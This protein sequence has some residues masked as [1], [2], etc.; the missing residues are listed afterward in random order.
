MVTLLTEPGGYPVAKMMLEIPDALKCMAPALGELLKEVTRQVERVAGLSPAAAYEEFETALRERLGAVERAAHEAALAALDID[1]SRLRID[2]VEYVRVGRH[3]TTFMS[4]A[5]PVPVMRSLY[6]RVG[7]RNGPTVDLVALR[8]AAV[9]GVWLPGAARA[10]AYLL[11]QGTSR[12]AES[13]A[14]ELGR[15]PYSRSSFERVGHAVG[16]IYASKREHVERDLIEAFEV[17]DEARSIS[18]SLDR[19]A[20]PMEEPRPRSVGRPRKGDAKRPVS[21]VFR[22]AYCGT[23]TIHDKN[24]EGL[25]TIRYGTMPGCD[26]QALCAALVD[27]AMALR[28]QRPRLRL[29][30]LCDG[31]PE[32]WNLLNDE[33]DDDI[34]RVTLLDFYH[35]IEKLSPAAKVL[36]GDDADKALKRWKLKLLNSD[37]AAKRI[38]RE[39]VGSEREGVLVDGHQ[40][41]HEAITYLR[42]NTDKMAYAS[43]RKAGLP[44][45][46]GNVEAT[47]KT[48]VG[49]RMKRCGAR[50]KTDTGE[51]IIQLR[52]LALSDRWPDAM[53]LTL[54]SP[55]LSIRRAA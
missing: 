50:W 49:V 45:G 38:L 51:H 53:A 12:E 21:R 43:A 9:E 35:V 17:P 15:L 34:K 19:V 18:L 47:C 37:C 27:D 2:R 20:V 31:A 22:M 39:L 46:S 24:G 5:G 55:R 7:E 6:R 30:L 44:I 28:S 32:M 36:F 10:M 40:P 41:V 4:Q 33:F 3:A 54:R 13:T 25:H 14:Q 11:Q 48:L 26:P 29:A 1:E 23:V 52:A 16:K 42:N 8:S